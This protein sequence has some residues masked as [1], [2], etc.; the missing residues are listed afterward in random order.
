[1]EFADFFKENGVLDEFHNAY[2]RPFVDA[3]GDLR[4]IMGRTLPIS[5]AALKHLNLANKVKDAFFISGEKLGIALVIEPYALDV[6]LKQ[7]DLAHGDRILSYWHGP[8]LPSNFVW[9]LDTGLP[10]EASLS[11]TDVHGFKSSRTMRGDWALLRLLRQGR[12]KRQDG[13]TCLVEMEESG[14]WAQF[15]VHLRSRTNPLD[16]A[17]C[18]FSLPESLR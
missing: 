11:I 6:R 12:I 16:P 13:N 18:G 15:L 7:V 3:K 4:P 10:P 8:V 5:E 1:V 14:R 2:V 17:S 9:P